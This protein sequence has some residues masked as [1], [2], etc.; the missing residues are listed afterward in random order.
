V[1]DGDS[2]LDS[3]EAH[4]PRGC[5]IGPGGGVDKGD[6]F[7]MQLGGGFLRLDSYVAPPARI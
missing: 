1:R 3:P 2:G 4:G 6:E 5:I 7:V